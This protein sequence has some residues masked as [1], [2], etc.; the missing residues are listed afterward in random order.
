MTHPLDR[1]VLYHWLARTGAAVPL[2]LHLV[3]SPCLLQLF[4]FCEAIKKFPPRK[5]ATSW[6]G[7]GGGGGGKSLV[8]VPLIAASLR[9]TNYVKF[10]VHNITELGTTA[11]ANELPFL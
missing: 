7:G 10:T 8:A 2:T 3:Y 11:G 9:E 1:I 6:G 5:W 4:V